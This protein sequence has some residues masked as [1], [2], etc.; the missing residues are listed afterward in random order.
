M[1]SDIEA[2]LNLGQPF[3]LC[4]IDNRL[5]LF[6]PNGNDLISAA[7][8][9]WWAVPFSTKKRETVAASTD[10]ESYLIGLN[11]TIEALRNNQLKKVVISRTYTES[12]TVSSF[13]TFLFR[14]LDSLNKK[15]PS[16]FVFAHCAEV[17][18]IWVG[19]T[20][21]ILLKSKAGDMSTVAL[22]GT[23]K[24]APHQA[25]WG[26]KEQREQQNV[27]DFIQGLL[28]STKVKELVIS[29]PYTAAAGHIE[30]I[31]SDIRFKSD[32]NAKEIATV[33]HPTSAVC[34][35]PRETAMNW[36]E[37]IEA[38]DRGYYAGAIGFYNETEFSSFVQ[39]RC[40]LLD[41]Q[42]KSITYY[43]GGGI[44]PDSD[45]ELE[46]IETENK[47]EVLRSVV[48]KI[49]QSNGI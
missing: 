19:A 44:M 20:P 1:E 38:H 17:G 10:K 3:A 49:E 8:H 48:K 2:S 39:L 43:A 42:S 7:G 37:Q 30:H 33:L 13:N 32:K 22:A 24:H 34:G 15:Y 23:R 29:K 5:S 45:P 41:V 18:K 14:L 27:V 47:I 31:K 35:M 21:E 9:R 12:L 6:N 40:A 4:F 46:W 26:H 28:D 11:K 25:P 16:A 36:I